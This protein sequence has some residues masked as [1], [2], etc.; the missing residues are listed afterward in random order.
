MEEVNN[1]SPILGEIT[2]RQDIIDYSDDGWGYKSKI[3]KLIPV[4][5]LLG[6]KYN[7][8]SSKI[9]YANIY[10]WFYASKEISRIFYPIDIS[11]DIKGTRA[12]RQN[13]KGEI[14]IEQAW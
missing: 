5:L 14:G 3:E 6:D 12:Y 10:I 4:Y 11:S 13:E 2:K 7:K 8:D 1:D 9:R